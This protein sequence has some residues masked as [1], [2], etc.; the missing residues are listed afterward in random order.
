MTR[1]EQLA[2]KLMDLLEFAQAGQ[3]RSSVLGDTFYECELD[4]TGR[5]VTATLSN[6]LR[7]FFEV[8]IRGTEDVPH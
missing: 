2:M 7:V 6:G 3:C 5:R 8:S 1:E 4:R